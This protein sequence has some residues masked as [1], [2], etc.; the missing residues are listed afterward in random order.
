[1][2]S[3]KEPVK[4][5]YSLKLYPQGQNVD[6]GIVENGVNVTLGPGDTNGEAHEIRTDAGVDYY[7]DEASIDLYLP[8]K[9]NGQM[10]LVLPGGGYQ[11]LSFVNEG[12]YVADWFTRRG[13]AACVVTY[14]LPCGHWSVPLNDVQNAMRYCR[15]H[16]EEWGIKQIGVIGF[17]AGGHL[18]ASASTLF[19]DEV[20]RPDFSILFYPVITFHGEV[21]ITRDNLIGPF[22]TWCN[23]GMSVKLF[24]ERKAQYETLLEHY[25]IENQVNAITPPTFITM[26]MDDSMV[27]VLE[28]GMKMIEALQRQGVRV[29][30]ACYPTGEHGYGFT[31]S[32]FG[33]DHIKEYRDSLTR[34][35]EQW[36]E[37]LRK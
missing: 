4:P 5:D 8:K 11:G 36:L 34:A 24:N 16:S 20:T 17:S 13:I 22:T 3:A 32:E 18:A 6:L 1:M 30:V 26:S 19:V 7:R 14:R 21:N 37:A 27:P 12:Y 35:L 2:L 33:D 28:H 23:E 10:V 31:T 29:E 9:C 15:H 25:S